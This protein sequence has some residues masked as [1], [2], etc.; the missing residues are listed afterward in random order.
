M[1]LLH[2]MHFVRLLQSYWQTH[3]DTAATPAITCPVLS[4]VATV[5]VHGVV[6]DV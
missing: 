5:N 4:V 2:Q 1:C 3:V 6:C